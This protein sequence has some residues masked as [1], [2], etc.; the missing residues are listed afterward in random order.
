M[1]KVPST[2]RTPAEI[3]PDEN[4]PQF[5]PAQKHAFPGRCR[6]CGAPLDVWNSCPDLPAAEAR[7]RSSVLGPAYCGQTSEEPWN[8]AVDMPGVGRVTMHDAGSAPAVVAAPIRFPEKFLPHS[9]D[10]C[11]K[12]R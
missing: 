2:L 7:L 5:T 11:A 4:T 12:K 3:P 1:T 9:A 10:I 6:D 8:F